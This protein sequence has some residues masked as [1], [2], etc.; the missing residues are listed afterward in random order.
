M[1]DEKGEDAKAGSFLAWY[2][3]RNKRAFRLCERLDRGRSGPEWSAVCANTGEVMW[4]EEGQAEHQEL[5]V[6]GP[7]TDF[8][9]REFNRAA[10]GRQDL[11]T[12]EWDLDFDTKP[13]QGLNRRQRRAF[14]K[15]VF[16]DLAPHLNDAVGESEGIRLPAVAQSL[17]SLPS[18]T[19]R[20][21]FRESTAVLTLRVRWSWG[22]WYNPLEILL[23]A[24]VLHEAD[25]KFTLAPPG[26]IRVL[27]L[28]STQLD[29]RLITEMSGAEAHVEK[30]A[31]EH[32]VDAVYFVAWTEPYAAPTL[33]QIL[34]APFVSARVSWAMDTLDGI[35]APRK[36]RKAITSAARIIVAHAKASLSRKATAH[37]APLWERNP[38]AGS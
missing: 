26:A 11:P 37:I 25:K 19:V 38:T 23:G 35:R 33:P 2:N 17:P 21:T 36:L 10:G 32:R 18:L 6:M 22:G 15:A 24:N 16:E 8:W 3:P 1:P 14:I 30:N 27:L 4:I 28:W 29:T 5:F 34:A 7:Q 31:S 13:P 12:G 20:M 9:Q